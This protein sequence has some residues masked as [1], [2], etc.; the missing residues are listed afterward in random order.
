[1]ANRMAKQNEQR[2]A[3]AEAQSKQSVTQSNSQKVEV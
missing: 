2:A 1:M 3:E